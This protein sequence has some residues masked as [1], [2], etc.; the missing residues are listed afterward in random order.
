MLI[1]CCVNCIC[2]NTKMK[3]INI[4]YITF[5]SI[6]FIFSLITCLNLSSKS[7]RYSDALMYLNEINKEKK[8]NMRLLNNS[9][10][11]YY[12]YNGE[13][14]YSSK[15]K[16]NYKNLFKK[17]KKI[18]L[19][20]NLIR[21]FIYLPLL[22]FSYFFLSS[23]LKNLDL[24]HNILFKTSKIGIVNFIFILFCLIFNSCLIYLRI[25]TISTD[26]EIGLYKI[27][28]T[29]NFVKHTSF[30]ILFDVIIIILNFI[31]I[32]LSYK[33]YVNAEFNQGKNSRISD[34]QK[35]L[36]YI[37]SKVILNTKD[38]TNIIEKN[39]ENEMNNDKN[40]NEIKENEKNENKEKY[41]I[42]IGNEKE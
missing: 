33:I 11:K 34:S 22:Y 29:T 36:P 31:C 21:F 25:L 26:E 15:Q 9:S 5:I 24:K 27:N 13:Q 32:G 16:I 6:S 37:N 30:N 12:T 7:S 28:T 3:T 10:G 17:W 41:E 2:K 19:S 18:E 14:Y 40:E 8:T 38:E 20:F 39:I 42:N 4:L 23:R 1:G 35:N